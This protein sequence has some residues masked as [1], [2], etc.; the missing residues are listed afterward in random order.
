MRFQ[1]PLISARLI[2]RYKR[3]LADIALEDGTEVAAHCPNPGSMLGLCEP[4]ARIWVEPNENPRKKLNFGWRLVDNENGHFVGIDTSAANKIIKEALII[5]QIPGMD[6]YDS[7]RS[8]VKYGTGSRVDF[9]LSKMGQTDI[10]LEIK[11]VTLMRNHG[12]AEFPDSPTD[13][14]LKHLHELAKV[15]DQGHRA[16]LLFLIQ[17]SDCQQF[18][19]ARDIDPAYAE[20]FDYALRK[21]VKILCLSCEV[22]PYTIDVDKEVPY[23]I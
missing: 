9:L 12:L 7:F 18:Q 10:Y 3:Y 17:R 14:G 19:I 13:R 2:R 23:K 4:G 11:S 1:T 16:V 5:G 20:G 8:E 22:S 15:V 21:G 6:T